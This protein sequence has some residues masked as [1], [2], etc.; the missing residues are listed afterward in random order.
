MQLPVA[1]EATFAHE[2][3]G[4]NAPV[5]VE[6]Y[7]PGCGP[8]QVLEPH[9]RRIANDYY[10]RLKVVKVNSAND[11]ALAQRYGVQ[12]APTLVIF[13]AGTIAEFIEGAPPPHRLVALAES[14][15]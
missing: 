11:P 2:V 6:F 5:L 13:Q 15:T 10:P 8:C 4:H 7:T 9:L 14:Y 12:M 1:N 3:L